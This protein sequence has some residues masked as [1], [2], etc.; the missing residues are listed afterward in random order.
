MTVS[1]LWLF[2]VVPWVSMQCVIVVFPGHTHLL[3]V[4]SVWSIKML[5]LNSPRTMLLA[6]S[7]FG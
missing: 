5:K 1:V 2:P 4:E 3:F 6:Q 7:I